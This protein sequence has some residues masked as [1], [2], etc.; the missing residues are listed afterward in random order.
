MSN[1]INQIKKFKVICRLCG[2]ESC[3]LIRLHVRQ[4]KQRSLKDS[5]KKY[6][7]IKVSLV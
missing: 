3:E 7:G 2:E 4:S 1:Y 6:I 5:I